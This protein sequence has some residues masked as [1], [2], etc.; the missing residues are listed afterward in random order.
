MENP[1]EILFLNIIK[2]HL[3][4]KDENI[5]RIHLIKLKKLGVI[6]YYICKKCKKPF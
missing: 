2:K 5:Y 6:N 4:K 3:K 1:K